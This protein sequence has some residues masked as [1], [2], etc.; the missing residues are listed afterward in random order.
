MGFSEFFIKRPIF[1]C[2]L[3]V[4][5]CAIGLI[6][7]KQLPLRH[8]PNITTPTVSIYTNYPGADPQLV[9]KEITIPIEN[10]LSTIAG[11][12]SVRSNSYLGKSWVNVDFQLGVNLVDAVNDIRN[13][14]AELASHL[15]MGTKAPSVYKKDEDVNPV[16]IIGFNAPHLDALQITDY[17]KRYTKPELEEIPGVGEVDFFGS[18]EYAVRIALDPIKMAA[19][20]VSVA[21][22]KK[23]FIDQNIDIPSG[24]IKSTNRYYTVITSAKVKQ[25]Q[26]FDHLVIAQSNGIA[27]HLSD[28]GKVSVAEDNNERLL[29]IN[30]KDAIGL[31]IL[32]QSTANPLELAKRVKNEIHHINQTLNNG[33]Q[34]TIVFDSTS[35]IKA[36]IKEVLKTFVE[37][38]LFVAV[39]VFLF[40]GNLRAAIIPIITIPICL[41]AVLA[42]MSWMG[43]DLNT[44]TMLAM[45]LA[46]GLVVDDAIVVLEN[47]HRHIHN[48]QSSLK[49]ALIGSKEI[50]FAVIAM[51]LTLA[52]VYAPMGFVEGFTGRLFQQF[53]ITLALTVFISGIVALTL[54]P[55]MCAYLLTTKSTRLSSK[56]N[57]LFMR[58]G[59]MYQKS[60]KWVFSHLK[61][62]SLICLSLMTLGILCFNQIGAEIAPEEDQSYIIAPVSSPTNA[63]LSYTDYYVRQIEKIYNQVDEQTTF[64]TS[65]RPESAFTLLKLTPW[66]NRSRSQQ[67]ISQWLSKK[68]NQLTGV[69]VF[70]RSP[71]PLGQSSSQQSFSFA[72]TGNTSY[73]RLHKIA[74]GITQTME[75]NPI[76]SHV[77]NQLTIDSEQLELQIN[78]KLANDLQVNLSDIAELLSTMLGGANP[79]EFNFAGQSYPV[80]MQLDQP[81]QH[82]IGIINQ[83]FVQSARGKM[84]PLSNLITVSTNTAPN[85]LP[86]LNRQRSANI[87]AEIAPG[88][89][90]HDAIVAIDNLCKQLLPDDVH[91]QF[92]G[93]SQDFIESNGQAIFAFVLALFFIYLVLAAQFESLIDPLI[94]LLSVPLCLCGA[95]FALFLTGTS[96]SIYS[97]IGM[98]TLI[99]LI[100]KHGIMITEFA[101]AHLHESQDVLAAITESAT[102]RLRP[103]LMTTL[104]MALGALP[105]LFAHGAGAESRG[106]LG[107]VIFTGLCFGTI[108]CIYVVP[109]AYYLIRRLGQPVTHFSVSQQGLSNSGEHA[110]T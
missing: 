91:Y 45:V 99:G 94:I 38:T 24:Q 101:N 59:Q 67:E 108:C 78:R 30:G 68:F 79:V 9:E 55:M 36:S 35:Y 102:I 50:T 33:M 75:K 97:Q 6:S 8:L 29:R 92:T 21:Q 103:I 54:S 17:V 69:S 15:P 14:V 65:V 53:G 56:V 77:R 31:A 61:L 87:S 42:P 90:M 2:V 18:K 19:R 72:L 39:V 46:I 27:V 32:P 51:T 106:Q 37:A 107:L 41:I 40:L 5:I 74:K 44:L 48:G 10:S 89:D 104:A 16:A 109:V 34:A 1:T 88:Y 58:L 71:Q 28:I 49:A 82:D 86:H 83:L 25:A 47:C 85:N 98:I 13:N 7:L 3:M 57:D 26:S 105:L 80:I 63:S 100:A 20:G 43:Y 66:E 84:I 52:A 4:L 64:L 110:V 12:K 76:F 22:V 93:S 73:E 70:A 23:A 96:L 60:L 95:I 62:F 11:V 81:N